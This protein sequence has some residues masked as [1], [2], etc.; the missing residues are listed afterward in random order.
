MPSVS[1]IQETLSLSTAELEKE[2]KKLEKEL[3]IWYYD[4]WLPVAAGKQWWRDEVKLNRL[5]TDK[6]DVL[7]TKK[8]SVTVTSEAM[9]LL[10]W[11]NYS[12]KWMRQF[13]YKDKHGADAELP[14]GKHDKDE[15]GHDITYYAAK[16]SD[17]AAGQKKYGGW[18]DDAYV[19]FDEYKNWVKDFRD[20]DESQGKAFQKYVLKVL[21]EKHKKK[22]EKSSKSKKRKRGGANAQPNLVTPAKKVTR[23]DE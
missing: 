5:L 19:K 10:A 6:V 21:Q 23:I 16:W 14:K 9:G 4:R 12:T 8:V 15:D 2:D 3:V 22:L 11:D 20:A 7:G 13:Q 17:G 18:S 1:G